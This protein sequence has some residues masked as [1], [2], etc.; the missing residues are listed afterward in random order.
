[1]SRVVAEGRFRVDRRRAL[2]KLERFQL[3]DPLR[4]VLELVSAGVSAG[5]ER[6]V[7]RNDSD[8][9]VLACRG[10]AVDRDQLDALFDHVFG[11]PDDAVGAMLQHL[12][13]GVLG[14]LGR[15]PVFVRVDVGPWRLELGDPASARAE[16]L[17]PPVDGVRVHV[18]ERLLSQETLVEALMLALRDPAE[19]RLVKGAARWCEVPIEI[20][21]RVPDTQPPPAEPLLELVAP[22]AHLWVVAGTEGH[23][24]DVVRHG[25]VV[26]ELH[27]ELS[28]C[29]VVGWI[30][31]DEVRL[32]AS[33]SAV[34]DSDLP[35]VLEA[36]NH[37]VDTMLRGALPRVW[38][39][40]RTQLVYFDGRSGRREQ[41]T[42]G[43]LLD[44]LGQHGIGRMSD[45]PG[46][47]RD[48]AVLTDLRGEAWSLRTLE[49]REVGWLF[50]AELAHWA[51]DRVVFAHHVAPLLATVPHARDL[52]DEV[53]A[54]HR[55]ELQRATLQARP[56]EP[57]AFE[58]QPVPFERTEKPWRVGI[59]LDDGRSDVIRATLRVDGRTAAQLT[60]DGPG[61]A[62]TALVEGPFTLNGVMGEV[63][64]DEAYQRALAVLWRTA[65]AAVE[66]EV[67][68]GG[69]RALTL[70]AKVLHR[71]F[72]EAAGS[73]ACRSKLSEL[74][75]SL[76]SVRVWPLGSTWV[77]TDALF[78]GPPPTFVVDRLP[79]GCPDD[80][81]AACLQV[82]TGWPRRM[83]EWLGAAHVGGEHLGR[84]MEAARKLA[85]PRR[86][87]RLVPPPPVHVALERMGLRGEL[88][89]PGLA[90]HRSLQRR[91]RRVGPEA[92]RVDV[93]WKG[94]CVGT[95]PV[96]VPDV[97]GVVQGD[98][99]ALDEAL[100]LTDEAVLQVKGWLEAATR[101][102]MLSLWSEVPEGQALPSSLMDWLATHA[103][104][105]PQP[106]HHRP[107]LYRLSGAA[108][109]LGELRRL[110]RRKK[111]SRKL[112]V[113]SHHPGDLPGFD[114]AV[115]A[116]G[117]ARKVLENLSR[118]GWRD[119][120][121]HVQ[122]A[123][124][125]RQLRL[126][127]PPFRPPERPL[128][129]TTVRDGDL[130]LRLWLPR[131]PVRCGR[132]RLF[133]LCDERVV[134]KRASKRPGLLGAVDG[135]PPNRRG[136][137]VDDPTALTALKSHC[138]DGLVDAVNHWL[139]GGIDGNDLPAARH[140]AARLREHRGERRWRVMARRFGALELLHDSQGKG[141]SV[142]Q[143]KAWSAAG[144][145][146]GRVASHEAAGDVPHPY[147]V[148]DE[149]GVS[150]VLAA[151][152]GREVPLKTEE[153]RAWREG[154]RRRRELPKV[155]P[156]RHGALF[157]P[158]RAEG[159][160][161][162]LSL[163]DTVGGLR[164]DPI[165]DDGIDL[166]DL[167]GPFRVGAVASVTG[168]GIEP[169]TDLT[170]VADPRAL[171]QR[172]EQVV[173]DAIDQWVA[174]GGLPETLAQRWVVDRGPAAPTATVP[175]FALQSGDRR[176][177]HWLQARPE[178]YWVSSPTPVVP[179]EGH[180]VVVL[181]DP[182]VRKRLRSMVPRM[183]SAEGLA[184]LMRQT[185][186]RLAPDGIPVRQFL[187]NGLL[188]PVEHHPCHVDVVVEHQ[189]VARIEPEPGLGIE[190]TVP[191]ADAR[192]AGDGT[193]RRD[194]AS[195]QLAE[196]IAGWQ[197]SLTEQLAARLPTDEW[198][199]RLLV[200]G[201]VR[202][203]G[204]RRALDRALEGRDPLVRAPIFRDTTHTWGSLSDVLAERPVR[205]VTRPWGAPD[206]GRVWL[207]DRPVREAIEAAHYRVDPY[208][209]ELE[210]QLERRR[211]LRARRV[212]L[213]RPPAHAT[214][215]RQG[216]LQVALWRGE[217]PDDDVMVVVD[218]AHLD[219]LALGAGGL[220]GYVAGPLKVSQGL[221]VKLPRSLRRLVRRE[222][223]ALLQAELDDD[224]AA[225][226][227]RA[228]RWRSSGG[229]LGHGALPE[230]VVA[231]DGLDQ[232]I[233][234]R[235]AMTE[236]SRVAAVLMQLPEERRRALE[237]LTGPLRAHL[238]EA[239]PP[240]RVLK[241]AARLAPDADERPPPTLPAELRP[242]VTRRQ[243]L[244]AAWWVASRSSVAD[245]E[246]AIVERL[247]G[248]LRAAGDS[249]DE[250]SNR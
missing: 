238:A 200:A 22:D 170:A 198:S 62:M 159:L 14:A 89:H 150:E 163:V 174:D 104:T 26:H 9:F 111:G 230:V 86:E 96:A 68:P 166:A 6:I 190:G 32:N 201:V 142:E 31:G 138:E 120:D 151:W 225:F 187:P 34:I 137:D 122:E 193:L 43:H 81:R 243:E 244:L 195:R 208:D 67:E 33:R 56:R 109:T 128:Y 180:P 110:D 116:T 61:P 3:E 209:R 218:G 93:L 136:T 97:S 78:E 241:Q 236:T 205:W 233:T 8:D 30:R 24:V 48:L 66:A 224:P 102:L 239:P 20:N 52:T 210:D 184:A 10:P 118:R 39:T 221:Q 92:G 149:P 147:L 165:S 98:E 37:Y 211:A 69:H 178:L 207:L 145:P 155:R 123:R 99:L 249:L 47:L 72:G 57:W 77:S 100:R 231:R 226:V 36:L 41:S 141:V 54:Q 196:R 114:D 130:T 28:P 197:R 13:V 246:L 108:L 105:I 5:A 188:W 44:L 4:Y 45:D 203:L 129:A 232:P 214:T 250:P 42:R 235:R 88:G 50:D 119:G 153:L 182:E 15:Q 223:V 227:A 71:T 175:V 112:V 27:L 242:V 59:R 134:A 132:T 229:D 1:V 247:V 158:L 51:G 139:K 87:P 186:K 217:G 25:V 70:L 124:R 107:V 156:R 65:L 80:L 106:E 12:A 17:D 162:Y 181:P 125:L 75:A 199:R 49:A 16:P 164:I 53:R 95:V 135:L 157:R 169:T 60:V 173:T 82:P 35:P 172:L 101:Q 204:S 64:H 79:A 237:E 113:L 219:T 215:S 183:K 11:R 90:V 121:S 76:R 73:E 74:P 21:G 18:R 63:A 131:E 161:G 220:S 29:R 40:D 55:L 160:E 194:D 19:A 222:A 248:A 176:S 94:V 152:L 2:D 185:P 144:H 177:V 146:I 202:L 133:A 189:V 212:E 168:P 234:L 83:G 117:S 154:Q 191:A 7:V 192:P 228:R 167:D 91:L 179:L 84:A 213:P 206:E 58:G 143:V 46:P 245:D 171:R 148:R 127:R 38:G 115:V 23:G 103:G 126:S 216:E 140:L 85:G 240:D